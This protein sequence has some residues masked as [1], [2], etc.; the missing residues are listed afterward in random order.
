MP[1]DMRKFKCVLST[2]HLK[3]QFYL[4]A[5]LSLSH[6]GQHSISDAL[7]PFNTQNRL[8]MLEKTQDVETAN[9]LA[10]GMLKQNTTFFAPYSAKAMYSYSR[11]DFNAMIQYTHEALARNPFGHTEYENYC[12]MLMAGI[13]QYQRA[14]DSTSV[15][16][17]RQELLW[18]Q[19]QLADN[20]QRLSKLGAMINDQ[21]VTELPADI[22]AY[23]NGIGG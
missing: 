15:A 8:Q 4:G 20:A 16:V 2:A 7:Y 11:G 1:P 14:G 22:I 21:P 5:A 10:D 23:I 3:N 17:C 12:R 6:F 9:T 19:Q 13:E 18:A